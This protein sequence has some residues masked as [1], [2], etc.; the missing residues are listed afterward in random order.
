MRPW[1]P[2]FG[3]RAVKMGCNHVGAMT[4]D[5]SMKRPGEA[6]PGR[7][8]GGST[9]AGLVRMPA[10]GGSGWQPGTIRSFARDTLGRETFA[11]AIFG[12]GGG[13]A[14]GTLP[15]QFG[16]AVAYADP[17]GL[18]EIARHFQPPVGEAASDLPRVA[19]TLTGARHASLWPGPLSPPPAPAQ[20]PE[21][22]ATVG[23]VGGDLPPGPAAAETGAPVPSASHLADAGGPSESAAPTVL[24]LGSETLAVLRGI[25]AQLANLTRLVKAQASVAK[26]PADPPE[27]FG[28]ITH[29]DATRPMTWPPLGESIEDPAPPVV[30]EA[31]PA[32]DDGQ[33]EASGVFAGDRQIVSAAEDAPAEDKPQPV[34]A[35]PGRDAQAEPHRLA[36]FPVGGADPRHM[37]E[38]A[39][40]AAR[41]HRASLAA[42][43]AADALGPVGAPEADV[44]GHVSPEAV[45]PQMVAP[46]PAVTESAT[47]PAQAA[48]QVASR[49]AAAAPDAAGRSGLVAFLAFALPRWLALI[50]VILAA[51]IVLHLL[52]GGSLDTLP[53]G[54]VS[55]EW[56]ASLFGRVYRTL[57]RIDRF[58]LDLISPLQRAVTG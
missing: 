52:T 42:R 1:L 58:M 54:L 50:G 32:R 6:S 3:M 47:L 51:G 35:H 20:E 44:P 18:S 28:E 11:P 9:A 55:A 40:R 29:G 48:A 12:A 16:L 36:M 21:A 19:A 31:V 7:A 27:P 57:E 8:E 25:E 30:G 23:A 45:V 22:E 14:P 38:A 53:A 2:S 17:A 56:W 46:A 5:R 24:E 43:Q 15:G 39:E 33:Q 49:D 10:P 41:F 13:P 26:P 37:A 34:V 4:D